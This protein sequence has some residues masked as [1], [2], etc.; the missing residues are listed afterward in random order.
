MRK[1][2]RAYYIASVCCF[3]IF[4][5]LEMMSRSKMVHYRAEL[6]E[7]SMTVRSMLK[8]FE[9]VISQ[10]IMKTLCVAIDNI[11]ELFSNSILAI[12][13]NFTLYHKFLSYKTHLLVCH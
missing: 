12:H 4:N 2:N 11:E 3:N 9:R 7:Y 13:I 8:H 10:T 1:C 6:E 5:G